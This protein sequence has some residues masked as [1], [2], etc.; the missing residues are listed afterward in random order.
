M[1]S[2]VG[3]LD[4]LRGN[5]RAVTE[6]SLSVF[7]LI[8]EIPYHPFYCVPSCRNIRPLCLQ[9]YIHNTTTTQNTVSHRPRSSFEDIVHTDALGVSGCGINS[10]A[11][12]ESHAWVFIVHCCSLMSW[13]SDAEI[14]IPVASVDKVRNLPTML[15]NARTISA[16]FKYAAVRPANCSSFRH[17]S[18]PIFSIPRS[19]F[20]RL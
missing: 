16:F 15:S 18:N 13:K 14:S 8:I 20:N 2:P 12:A 17:S 7:G 1:S 9:E 11:V 3:G 5:L 6:F 10:F 4:P 19:T